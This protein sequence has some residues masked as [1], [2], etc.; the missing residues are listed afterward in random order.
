MGIHV[1]ETHVLDYGT[2]LYKN[3]PLETALATTRIKMRNRIKGEY[4]DVCYVTGYINDAE[5]NVTRDAFG[6]LCEDAGPKL[7]RY[8]QN[9][10]FTSR[11]IVP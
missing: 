6:E 1:L 4:Q 8:K 5:F 7:A 10:N 9:E 2:A 11:W 3:R